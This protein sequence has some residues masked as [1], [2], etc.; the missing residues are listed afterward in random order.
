MTKCALLRTLTKVI[1]QLLRK[2]SPGSGSLWECFRALLEA[3]ARL[4]EVQVENGKGEIDEASDREEG[5]TDNEDGDSDD[6][7]H[8]E[9]EEE[10]LKRYAEAVASL[11]NGTVVEEGDAEDYDEG[12]ELGTLENLDEQKILRSLLERDEILIQKHSLPSQLISSF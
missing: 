3:F 2:E 12:I 5:E 6:D 9:T 10:F 8:E 1:E 4:K 7:I 11:E